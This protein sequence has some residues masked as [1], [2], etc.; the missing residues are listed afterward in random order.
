ME[1][2]KVTPPTQQM[3]QAAESQISECRGHTSN[4]LIQNELGA[5][6]GLFGVPNFLPPAPPKK[7]LCLSSSGLGRGLHFQV[8]DSLGHY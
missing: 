4:F 2:T 5:M 1:N 7:N 3:K 8:L 6:R